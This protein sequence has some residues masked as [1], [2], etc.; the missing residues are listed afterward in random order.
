MKSTK[1]VLSAIMFF[2]VIVLTL[3]SATAINLDLVKIDNPTSVSPG[4]Q[5]TI[6]FNLTNNNPDIN[7]T[8]LDWSGS[9]TNKGQWILLPTLTSLNFNNTATLTA[10]LSIPASEKGTI[11][12]SIVVKSISNP[13]DT[14]TLPYTISILST[15]SLEII[16]STQTISLGKNATITIK[17]TGN[18]DLNNIL[19]TEITSFGAGFSTNNLKVNAGNSSNLI[20]VLLSGISNLNFGDNHVVIQ[21]MDST[22]TEAVNITTINVQKS[23]CINGPVGGN[24]SITN[25]DVTNDGDGD[26]DNW[27][28]LDTIDVEV[29]IDNLNLD[30]TVDTVIELG[31]F[32]SAGRNIADDMDFL[33]ESDSEDEKIDVRIDEDDSETVHFIF[34]IP[35][36]ITIGSYKVAVK[37]Y[38]DDLGESNMCADR[39]G[40]LIFESVSIEE[41]EDTNDF[42]AVE[43]IEMP[44][45]AI[46]GDTVQGSFD[47]FNVGEDDE[48]RVR[49]LVRSSGLNLERTF[50]ITNF[51]IGDSQSIDIDFQIPSNADERLHT[52][53]FIPYFDYRSGNYREQGDSFEHV[54][55][56]FGCVDSGGDSPVISTSFDSS[57]VAGQD[58][59]VRA[60]ITNTG[61]STSLFALDALSFSSWADLSS[62]SPRTVTL[63]PG[64]SV[65][66]TID[67]RVHDDAEGSQSMIV[68]AT[69][70]SDV[71]TQQVLVTISTGTDSGNGFSLPEIFRGSNYIWWLV[72]VNVILVVLIIAVAIRLSRR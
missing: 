25:I 29:D 51:D 11:S 64:Q 53:D 28:L 6:T 49:I 34:K 68:Q 38:D 1:F 10:T 70:D 47:I 71:Y 16:P 22:F 8:D 30:D 19:L 44:L 55:R 33:P 26:D 12:A 61:S 5:L 13:D 54:I 67:L 40:D 66:V 46:C 23:F 48:D 3:S 43:N 9:T 58:F 50:E 45:E 72:L 42:I 7:Y 31:I 65:D 14:D 32:D 35:A 17:N 24:L 18:V 27:E 56:V 37:A 63:A 57:P 4:T 69:T 59:T 41:K 52:I 36:D 21:A 60:T 39:D 15:P 20:T 2:A 62:I